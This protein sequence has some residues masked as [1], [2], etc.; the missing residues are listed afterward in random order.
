MKINQRGDIIGENINKPKGRHQWR[1]YKSDYV[2]F[3]DRNIFVAI[4]NSLFNIKDLISWG[5]FFV[6]LRLRNY[7][8]NST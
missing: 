8:K 2:Y 4:K 6:A 7:Y 3:S 5:L 1:K